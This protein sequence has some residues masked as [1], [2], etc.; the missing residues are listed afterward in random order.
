MS[1]SVGAPAPTI[2][3][4]TEDDIEAMTEIYNQVVKDSDSIWIDEDVS[5]EDR[6]GWFRG[7]RPDDVALVAVDTAGTVLGY[8]ACFPFRAKSGYWPTV[9]LTILLHRDHRGEGV[10]RLLMEALIDRTAAAGRHVLV[11]GIDGGNVGSIRFH[12]RHGFREVAR[13]PGVGRKMGRPVDL[14]L[15]QRELQP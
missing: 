13:M 10:G 11:A 7:L 14:V 2:R 8:T 4:A 5:V 12:E 3:D 1:S 15:M 6:L 9:E